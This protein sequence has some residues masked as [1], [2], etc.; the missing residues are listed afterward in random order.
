[1]PDSIYLIVMLLLSLGAMFMIALGDIKFIEIDFF[2]MAIA[3]F[4]VLALYAG[5][6]INLL[7]NLL[8]GGVLLLISVIVRFA[9]PRGVGIGDYYLFSFMG[10][11]AG[12]DHLLLLVILN[13]LF[14]VAASLYYSWIRGK[15][16]FKSSFPAAAPGMPRHCGCVVGAV[17]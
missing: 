5:L 9:R 2:A 8:A 7:S 17:F 4:A 1:M 6:D 16:M 13:L 11:V 3:V 15:R 12:L 14:S 10:F